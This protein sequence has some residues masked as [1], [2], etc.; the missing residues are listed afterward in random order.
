MKRTSMNVLAKC[1]GCGNKDVVAGEPMFCPKC[2]KKPHP[3]A[4][5]HTGYFR[6]VRDGISVAIDPKDLPTLF[7]NKKETN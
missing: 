4:V 1:P 5:I 2:D 6:S 3:D 7:P